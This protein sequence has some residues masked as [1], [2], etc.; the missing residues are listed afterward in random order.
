MPTVTWVNTINFSVTTKGYS[1]MNVQGVTGTS[2]W[3]NFALQEQS[4]S[5]GTVTYLFTGDENGSQQQIPACATVS[6][7]I[8]YAVKKVIVQAANNTV[9]ANAPDVGVNDS[10]PYAPPLTES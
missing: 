9:E 7:H 8:P 5:G 3:N 1:V 10:A 4:S 6:M 2:P